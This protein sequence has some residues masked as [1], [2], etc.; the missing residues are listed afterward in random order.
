MHGNKWEKAV[1]SLKE[2]VQ[3][4]SNSNGYKNQTVSLFK[5]NLCVEM[6]YDSIDP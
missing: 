6:V 3:S 2:T 5:F 1:N 4:V